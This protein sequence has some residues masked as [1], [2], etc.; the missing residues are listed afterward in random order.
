MDVQLAIKVKFSVTNIRLRFSSETAKI[1]NLKKWNYF[2]K[3]N[4]KSKYNNTIFLQKQPRM[5]NDL[6]PPAQVVPPIS[7][8]QLKILNK[9]I[10]FVD[11][12]PSLY[13]FKSATSKLLAVLWFFYFYKASNNNFEVQIQFYECS[14]WTANFGRRVCTN[15]NHDFQKEIKFSLEEHLCN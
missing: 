10:S 1:E 6:E 14:T 5:F 9:K 15:F 11:R 3:K 2:V 8:F 7:C 4:F 12:F 13:S